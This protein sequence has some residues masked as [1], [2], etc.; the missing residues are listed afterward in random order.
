MTMGRLE[1][2]HKTN[3]VE[4]VAIGD[5]SVEGL[6][7]VRKRRVETCNGQV[8]VAGGRDEVSETR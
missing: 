5:E 8:G 1:G 4:E 2:D 7:L 6:V 3:V